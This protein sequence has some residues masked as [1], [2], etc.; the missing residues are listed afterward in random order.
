MTRLGGCRCKAVL[1]EWWYKI[2]VKMAIRSNLEKGEKIFIG[3]TVKPSAIVRAVAGLN[4]LMGGRLC[5]VL[6]PSLQMGF[7]SR[8]ISD[9]VNSQFQ[10]AQLAADIVRNLPEFRVSVTE[11]NRVQVG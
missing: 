5:Q 11:L 10:S 9:S 6:H 1:H 7:V 4:Q 2:Q 3:K 8:Q